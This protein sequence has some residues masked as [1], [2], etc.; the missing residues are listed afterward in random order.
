MWQTP[1][2]L[3][4]GI[5]V[6]SGCVCAQDSAG[7]HPST[8]YQSLQNHRTVTSTVMP[9]SDLHT[10]TYNF[11]RSVILLLSRSVCFIK[12]LLISADVGAKSTKSVT[13]LL[14]WLTLWSFGWWWY[15]PV[16]LG[17]LSKLQSVTTK[18]TTLSTDFTMI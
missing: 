16:K 14:L 7:S 18:T 1:L 17:D 5:P 12:I 6:R 9:E 3:V 13:W 8:H 11:T 2:P 4:G 15:I 10:E